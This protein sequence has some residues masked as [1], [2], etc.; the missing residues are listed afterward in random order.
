MSNKD[1]VIKCLNCIHS[2]KH[3]ESEPCLGCYHVNGT[4]RRWHKDIFFHTKDK[5]IQREGLQVKH[6]NDNLVW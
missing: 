5:F 3:R 4:G 2:R 1:H 6:E